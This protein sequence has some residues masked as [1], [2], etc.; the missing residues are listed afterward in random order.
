[1]KYVTG[2][3]GIFFRAK[4]PDAL[5]AWYEKHFGINQVNESGMW[6]QEAGPTVFSPFKHDTDYFGRKEQQFMINIRV[7]NIDEFVEKLSADGVKIDDER[8]DYEYG[9]FAWVYDPEEN[10][11]ELWEE[12]K[13]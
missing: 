6:E 9:K 1:M 3:G 7:N 2:I 13:K 5:A 11:I 12:P 4:D 10:K 8:M